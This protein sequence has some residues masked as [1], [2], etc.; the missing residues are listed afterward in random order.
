MREVYNN[1]TNNG[2]RKFGMQIFER[3]CQNQGINISEDDK[4]AVYSIWDKSGH[5]TLT[6]KEFY[7]GIHHEVINLRLLK[8]VIMI[9]VLFSFSYFS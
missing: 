1:I 7:D 3:V 6:F 9:V 4:L 8:G 2:E 5:G